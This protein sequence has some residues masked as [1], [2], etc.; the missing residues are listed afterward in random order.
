MKKSHNIPLK[1]YPKMTSVT[2]A[3]KE[4]HNFPPGQIMHLAGSFP[5]NLP[6]TINKNRKDMN[7]TPHVFCFLRKGK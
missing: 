1:G 7:L 4:N 5:G 2:S 6:P 3:I